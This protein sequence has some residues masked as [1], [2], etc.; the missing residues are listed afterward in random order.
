LNQKVYQSLSDIVPV[1]TAHN[2]GEKFVFLSQHDTQT[3]LTQFAYSKLMP[4]EDVEQHLHPTMEECFYFISGE[5][6]FIIA[7]KT[8]T[9]KP[10]T[11]FRVP[12]NMNH[13]LKIKGTEPLTF[14][15]FGIATQ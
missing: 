13:A 8:F 7:D 10:S 5:G 9:I 6:E 3:L 14:V 11:F 2:F 4:G 12:A 15:Y 1:V